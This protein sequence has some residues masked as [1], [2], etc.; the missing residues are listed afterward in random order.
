MK[1]IT[2]L[3]FFLIGLPVIGLVVLSSWK[4]PAPEVVINKV[5]SYENQKK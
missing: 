5:V 3:L 1:R 4:I 2:I